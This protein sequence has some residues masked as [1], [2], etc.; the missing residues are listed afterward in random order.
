M[1]DD[2]PRAATSAYEREVRLLQRDHRVPAVSAALVRKDRPVWTYEAA[3]PGY[4]RG[5]D[6]QY[7]IGSVTKTFTAALVMQARDAGLL[8]LD[9]PVAKH[10]DV[11]QHGDHTIRR[12]L[13]HSSGLAREPYG[14]VW[15]T[16]DVPDTGQVLSDLARVESVLPTSRRFHYSNLGF[17]ILGHLVARLAGGSWEELVVDRLIQPLGLT[18]TT[19]EPVEPV[20]QGY[21]VDVFSDRVRPEPHVNFGGVNPAAQLWSTAADMATWAAFLAMP[22]EKVLARSTVDEMVHPL[23]VTDETDWQRAFGLGLMV[24]PRGD[25]VVHVGHTGGMPG[26]IAGVYCDRTTGT[27]AAVLGSSGT[28]GQITVVPHKLLERS[29]EL[30]PADIEPWVPGDAPPDELASV[31][32]H[33]FTEGTEF[34]F[35]WTD[36]HLEARATGQPKQL[37]PAVFER[38]SRDLYRTVSGREAGEQLRLTRDDAGKVTRMNW[39]TYRV[40]RDQQTFDQQQ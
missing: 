21:L 36:G 3:A 15:D 34:T 10:L 19:V 18:R 29:A 33:W 31:L 22:D 38:V 28:A 39:A 27:G 37:P 14:D 35:S 1:T 25:R 20:A 32:G 26:F 12:L 4:G 8:D 30:D 9:D 2:H 11:P 40:T 23:M 7:R 17:A 13:S 24:I 6:A 5:V 16:L